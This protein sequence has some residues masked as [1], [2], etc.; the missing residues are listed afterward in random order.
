MTLEVLISLIVACGAFL[1]GLGGIIGAVLMYRKTVALLEYRM[2]SVERKLDEHNGYA[3][4]LGLIQQDMAVVK[5][6]IEF[7][8]K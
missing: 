7:L 8:T 1:T 2:A 6:K 4:K 5:T 3:E